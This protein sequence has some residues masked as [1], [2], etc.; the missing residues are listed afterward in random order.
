LV[1]YRYRPGQELYGHRLPFDRQN[2]TAK[3]SLES[4]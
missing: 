1:G 2:S 3:I 4:A